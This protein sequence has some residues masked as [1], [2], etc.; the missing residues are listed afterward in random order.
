MFQ[1][2]ITDSSLCCFSLKF[3]MNVWCDLLNCGFNLLISRFRPALLV[4]TRSLLDNYDMNIIFHQW[5]LMWLT[6]TGKI[7][8]LRGINSEIL[9]K[10][11]F[12]AANVRRWRGEGEFTVTALERRAGAILFECE[13]WPWCFYRIGSKEAA[14]RPSAKNHSQSQGNVSST[15]S[16][17][18]AEA[19]KAK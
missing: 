9:Y 6:G 3:R 18:S 13:P 11:I 7:D 8:G 14:S 2:G 12:L 5:F 4:S 1:A 10:V 17:R 16:V 19:S 15:F